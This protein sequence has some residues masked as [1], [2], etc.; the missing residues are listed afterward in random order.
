M[1]MRRFFCFSIPLFLQDL[2]QVPGG[3]FFYRRRGARA[4]RRSLPL[5]AFF[6][7][8]ALFCNG[9][10]FAAEADDPAQFNKKI[11]EKLRN[12][13]KANPIVAGKLSKSASV[14]NFLNS[15]AGA[16]DG[17]AHSRAQGTGTA[18]PKASASIAGAG[19][20][21]TGAV[22]TGAVATGAVATG[23]GGAATGFLPRSLPGG[24]AFS[25]SPDSRAP[26]SASGL[27]PPGTQAPLTQA[28][29][30]QDLPSLHNSLPA[31]GSPEASW[32]KIG[33]PQGAPPRGA[34]PDSE[35]AG[36]AG[37]A[38]ASAAGAGSDFK[39]GPASVP[40]YNPQNP[41]SRLAGDA[42]AVDASAADA[43]AADAGA[44]PGKET[45]DYNNEGALPF[46]QI[47]LPGSQEENSSA[48]P[49]GSP[50]AARSSPFSPGRKLHPGRNKIPYK[51]ATTVFYKKDCSMEGGACMKVPVLTNLKNVIFEYNQGR[52]AKQS[53]PKD[54]IEE[55]TAEATESGLESGDS[56]ERYAGGKGFSENESGETESSGL[57]PAQ[58]GQA[59][60]S[61][62]SAPGPQAT[63]A[64][65]SVSAAT[66]PPPASASASAPSM[67]GKALI[68]KA[69]SVVSSAVKK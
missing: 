63:P 4:Q 13:L 9:S 6:V 24:P 50:G 57:N 58:Q 16:P 39:R 52:Y 59:G 35:N 32:P 1:I 62:A 12:D 7:A 42:S 20:V 26:P 10:A 67:T 28:P 37:V 25:P 54:D 68:Q 5:F 49:A 43:G 38:D 60:R 18:V 29:L 23:S 36:G 34:P 8:A 40:L 53:I 11:F 33:P 22:Q 46:S 44:A 45:F 31:E 47:P 55:T 14:R 3:G 48:D 56:F 69:S 27:P 61:L 65:A 30:T 66:A 64:S 21:Q 19:A 17:A 51:P 15:P 41:D 2:Q